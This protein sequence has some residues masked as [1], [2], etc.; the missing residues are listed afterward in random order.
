MAIDYSLFAIP[1]VKPGQ[2]SRPEHRRSMRLDKAEQE[3]ACRAIVHKRDHGKCRVPGCKDKA[4]HLH[5]IVYRSKGG[6]WR[7]ENI[8]SLCASHHHMVHLGKITI[9][10]NADDELI[11]VGDRKAL[12][13]KL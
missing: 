13:F 12:A 6:K 8:A 3:R 1:K 9:S 7:P 11:I 5:H 2:Q 10:G 4:E